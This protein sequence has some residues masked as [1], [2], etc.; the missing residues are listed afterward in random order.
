MDRLTM[1]R[2]ENINI[3][4]RSESFTEFVKIGYIS[5]FLNYP[6]KDQV[7]FQ[8]RIERNFIH[9]T[10]A[11]VPV[12][13]MGENSKLSY[14]LELNNGVIEVEVDRSIVEKIS[15]NNCF[16]YADVTG[17]TEPGNYKVTVSATLPKL[18]K[19]VIL[20]EYTPTSVSLV[21]QEKEN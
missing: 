6:G 2:T 17:I 8:G 19:E 3:E 20:K 5:N 11:P 4:G 15:Y 13:I 10:I 21:V 1:L 16:L 14:T 9:K 7:Q 18:E 12:G